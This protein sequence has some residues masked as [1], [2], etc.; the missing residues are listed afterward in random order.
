MRPNLH[1][2]NLNQNFQVFFGKYLLACH[3]KTSVGLPQPK[4][5]HKTC[6]IN[7]NCGQRHTS[8]PCF[9]FMCWIRASITQLW[10]SYRVFFLPTNI[11]LKHPLPKWSPFPLPLHLTIIWYKLS[12]KLSDI[13]HSLFIL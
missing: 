12:G 10:L 3:S 6:Q 2:I 5:I 8:Q 9:F 4:N 7:Q 13:S 1:K 11:L